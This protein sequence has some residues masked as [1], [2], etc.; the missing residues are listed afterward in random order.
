M[1]NN[2]EIMWLPEPEDKNYPAAASYLS[3]IYDTTTVKEII[4]K[5]KKAPITQFMAKDI[6]RAS[7]QSLLGVSNFRVE[8]NRKKIKEGIALSPILLVRDENNGRVIIA[9]GY[10]RICSVYSFNEEALLPC[11]IC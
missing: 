3:L 4:K 7:G 8:K 5:L 9:D 1:S 6:F 2:H 11:K 10:H